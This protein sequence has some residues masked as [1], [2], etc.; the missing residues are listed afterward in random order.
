MKVNE[1]KAKELLKGMKDGQIVMIVK[2]GTFKEPKNDLMIEKGQ[3]DWT[4]GAGCGLKKRR[5]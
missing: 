5:R 2:G 4:S 3:F 1:K